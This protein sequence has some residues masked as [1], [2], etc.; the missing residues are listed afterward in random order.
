[1]DIVV[2]VALRRRIPSW[3][4]DVQIWICVFVCVE[5]GHN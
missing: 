5:A 3:D 1:V 2:E 4:A